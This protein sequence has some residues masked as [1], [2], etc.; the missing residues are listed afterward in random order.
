MPPPSC[1]SAGEVSRLL[2]RRPFRTP[3]EPSSRCSAPR[4]L[5]DGTAWDGRGRNH[6]DGRA[7]AGWRVLVKK[8]VRPTP[9]LAPKAKDDARPRLS[10]NWVA[11]TRVPVRANGAPCEFVRAPSLRSQRAWASAASAI[12]RVPS[13]APPASLIAAPRPLWR[14]MVCP[15]QVGHWPVGPGGN[16]VQPQATPASLP[17]AARSYPPQVVAS[18]IPPGHVSL[19]EGRRQLAAGQHPPC[20]SGWP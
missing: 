17:P 12:W 2:F 20:S 3:F 14:E 1:I 7:G 9:A 19:G 10:L 6:R 4:P 8:A 13:L 5:S 18:Y 15:P 11:A 16:S